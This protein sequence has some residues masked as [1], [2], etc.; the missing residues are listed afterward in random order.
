MAAASRA[1]TSQPKHISS[2]GSAKYTQTR[3]TRVRMRASHKCSTGRIKYHLCACV[4]RTCVHAAMQ[5]VRACAICRR[6]RVAKYARTSSRHSRE[7]RVITAVVASSTLCAYLL[8][9]PIFTHRAL[10][11]RSSVCACGFLHICVLHKNMNKGG[12]GSRV[13]G[14]ME[15]DR[16]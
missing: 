15:N 4:M 12:D 9:V 8:C 2:A 10:W 14:A 1:F 13:R 6:C 5:G 11:S 7:A 3:T 16:A